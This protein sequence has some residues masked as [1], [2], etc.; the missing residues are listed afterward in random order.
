M[1]NN[2]NINFIS[3]YK[4]FEDNEDS[5]ICYK[6]QLLQAFNINDYNDNEDLL[7][8]KME[9]IYKILRENK[10]LKEIFLLLEKKHPQLKF[11]N[12][13]VKNLE[14]FI[15]LQILFS[16]DYFYI[17]HRELCYFLLNKDY[18][19]KNIKNHII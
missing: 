6:L 9:N 2:Y 12:Y 14:N 17:F 11:I 10:Y 19:F 8:K 13:N 7:Q 5:N 3:T 4:Q 15:Y 18:N 1:E 16:Y